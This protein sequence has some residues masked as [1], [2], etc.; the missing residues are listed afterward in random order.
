MAS[1]LPDALRFWDGEALGLFPFHSRTPCHDD[2]ESDEENG[3]HTRPGFFGES[4]NQKFR[5]ARKN[6]YEGNLREYFG[7]RREK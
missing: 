2:S 3:T 4:E 1:P 5:K 7:I 6:E